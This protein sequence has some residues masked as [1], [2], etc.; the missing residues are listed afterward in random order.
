M[1]GD[2]RLSATE[3]ALELA[4][5]AIAAGSRDYRDYVWLGQVLWVVGRKAEVEPALR[6]AVT[7]APDFPAPRVVLVE[8]LMRMGMTEQ[9]QAA[10][11]EAEGSLAK[12]KPP[13][14][15]ARCYDLVGR[16]EEAEKLYR[17]VL[18]ESP[19]RPPHCV[20]SRT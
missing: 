15:L 2:F 18:A 17:A 19:K 3:L 9:A 7:L 14:A 12:L 6:Q 13:L 20:T 10:V 5:K 16:N 8:H 4:N 11:R 1:T